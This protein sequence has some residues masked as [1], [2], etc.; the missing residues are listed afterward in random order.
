MIVLRSVALTLNASPA[1]EFGLLLKPHPLLYAWRFPL[2]PIKGK[3]EIGAAEVAL[4]ALNDRHIDEVNSRES[5]FSGLEGVELQKLFEFVNSS[6]IFFVNDDLKLPVV[7]DGFGLVLSFLDELESDELLLAEPTQKLLLIELILEK[8][9][10]ILLSLVPWLVDFVLVLIFPLTPGEVLM[11][12][13]VVRK[14]KL[15]AIVKFG[16]TQ[17]ALDDDRL[18]L[19]DAASQPTRTSDGSD[20]TALEIELFEVD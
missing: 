6:W 12:R 17:L 13:I 14:S 16:Q 3:F 4:R 18:I 1:S 5:Y 2:E 8:H 15:V 7:A 9:S 19:V 10:L 11:G 20:R